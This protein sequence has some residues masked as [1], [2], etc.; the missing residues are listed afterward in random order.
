MI[1]GVTFS[2][3]QIFYE[4]GRVTVFV[5]A[6]RQVPSAQI[7]KPF[8]NRLGL[9]GVTPH[10]ARHSYISTLQAAGIE[11]ATVAKLAGHANPVATLGVYKPRGAGQRN[12][13]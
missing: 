12:R 3:A 5:G 4:L 7:W 13:G 9:E 8:L 1:A 10:S 6:E 11:L 2:R